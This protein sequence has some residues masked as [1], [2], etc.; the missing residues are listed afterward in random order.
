MTTP[1]AIH[2]RATTS[3]MPATLV[4]IRWLL[5]TPRAAPSLYAR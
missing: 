1:S 4:V 5:S 2:P 3:A